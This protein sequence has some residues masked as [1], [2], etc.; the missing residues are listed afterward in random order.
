M[1]NQL[2]QE[3]AKAMYD[4]ALSMQ[5]ASNFVYA[6]RVAKQLTELDEPFY[7]PFA[8]AVESQCYYSLG[9]HAL[10]NEVL[11][12]ITRLTP[13][14]KQ[15]LNPNWLAVCYQRTGDFR[16]ARAVID[17]VLQLAPHD[18]GA[19]AARAEISLLQGDATEA[20]GWARKLRE[21]PEPTFQILG[22]LFAAF[23][24]ARQN[25][26]EESRSELTW[27]GQFILS[28][29]NIPT[30]FW[31][32]RDIIPLL[33]GIGPNAE[34]AGLV[35]AALSNRIQFPEF[36]DKWKAASLIQQ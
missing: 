25:R 13:E 12:R 30:G 17:E 10:E 6:A 9:Q 26:Q 34:T 22:R 31:D 23:A 20:E 33:D 19:T 28:S 15:L 5:R 18:V 27:I 3:H 14:Q 21:R 2:T 16:S 35:L 1:A 8:L 4:L 24:L 36:A 32:Y 11:K 7:Q 29:G